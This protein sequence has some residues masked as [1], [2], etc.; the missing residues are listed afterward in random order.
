MI[1]ARHGALSMQSAGAAHSV[2]P[3]DGFARLARDQRHC[4]L[5]VE[6]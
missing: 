5:D 1:R 3:V 4:R 2:Q 6:P